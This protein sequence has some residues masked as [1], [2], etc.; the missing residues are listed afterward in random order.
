MD[1]PVAIIP[2]LLIGLPLGLFLAKCFIHAKRLRAPSALEVLARDRR[3]PVVYFRP[4]TE[5]TEAS[6]PTVL[7]SWITEEEQLAKVMNDIGPL[8]A[9][10]APREKTASLGAARMYVEEAK[11]HEAAL[12]LVRRA[13]LVMMRI[14][15]SAGFWWELEAVVSS[16]MPEQLILLIP[17]KQA[18]YDEFQRASC[19]LIPPALP[20]ITDWKKRRWF[21]GSLKAVIYF[22]RKWTPSI[23]DLQTFRPPLLRRSLVR[24]LTP[25]LKMALRP[26]YENLALRWTAP[27]VDLRIA[28]LVAASVLILFGV[29]L[30]MA[31][32]GPPWSSSSEGSYVTSEVSPPSTAS[33]TAEAPMPSGAVAAQ[34][35]ADRLRENPELRR[36]VDSLLAQ[37]G[38]D[39][40]KQQLARA[41]LRRLAA[42]L[43]RDGMRRLD[44]DSLLTKA[45][46]QRKLLV[47]AN[48]SECAAMARGEGGT[49]FSML[50]SLDTPDADQWFDLT[51]RAMV[52]ELTQSPPVRTA[53]SADIERI[54][55]GMLVDLPE[56]D[57]KVLLGALQKGVGD[58]DEQACWVAKTLQAG[59]DEL[60]RHDQIQWLLANAE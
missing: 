52:A 17:N 39:P 30:K 33:T 9:I 24:P 16:K 13:R 31:V 48:L 6:K 25:V 14:G 56:Q 58:S 43:A 44:D 36:R 29:M 26:V 2:S 50:E 49:L 22:D 38:S 57:Q 51:Y 28:G 46:I 40:E 3:A 23:V 10:G 4:F 37:A 55:S 54:L 53:S 1:W 41:E 12:A 19:K 35:F 18:L 8:V 42:K 45:A 32:E 60:N 20:A 21:R 47:Q 59:Y 15:S 11:W 5:D 27:R 34:R 7:A